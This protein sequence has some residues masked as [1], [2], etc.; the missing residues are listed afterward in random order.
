MP[1]GNRRRILVVT[2][3]V[4]GPQMAGPAI[5]ARHVA[6][7]L[8]NRHDVRLISTEACSIEG[9]GF[10]ASFADRAQ[11]VAHAGW[12]EVVIFQGWFLTHHPEIVDMDRILVA[13]VYDPMHLEQL[14]QARQGSGSEQ[15]DA[16]LHA[17]A[18]LSRQLARADFIICASEA[19]RMLWLG[20]LA[21]LGR[22]NPDLYSLDPTYRAFLDVVPFGCE[23]EFPTSH[24]HAIRGVLP[25]VGESDIVLLWN[26]GVY[27]WF[28]PS[29]LVRA[30][31]ILEST[32]PDI[33]LVFMGMKHPYPGVPQ[34][35]VATEAVALAE[36]LGLRDRSV[37]F[38][39]EWVAYDKRH[40]YLADADVTVS[41]HQPGLEA[42]FAF[43]TRVL[44]SL[45]AGLPTIVTEGG[46]LSDLV[47]SRGL[48]AVV[49]PGDP[50]RLAEA[51]AGLVR[52]P[53]ALAG[54]RERVR[55]IASEFVWSEVLKPLVRFCDDPRRAPDLLNGTVAE[56]RRSD[57]GV[58]GRSRQ[59]SGWLT[60]LGHLIDRGRSR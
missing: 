43:R 22:V 41:T 21:A 40:E 1:D 33:R 18:A 30:M 26:G 5:R 4:L 55:V 36:E 38:N 27:N 49:P 60:R 3:D 45:W 52:N 42:D 56:D 10:P 58:D 28:D 15:S 12:A 14:E 35:R 31:A 57:L 17:T 8:S 6:A 13:D 54:V 48:G 46:T 50:Q 7:E 51:I 39:F 24:H 9:D 44:D 23:P 59:R 11:A 29:T 2:P 16:W 37:F 19:Q 53:V 25:G 34:M 20:H 47:A 32:E